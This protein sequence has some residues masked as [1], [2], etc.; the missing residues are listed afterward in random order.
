MFALVMLAAGLAAGSLEAQEWSRF[1][2]PNGTGLSEAKTVPVSWTEADFNWKTTLPGAGHSSPVLW[3]SRIFLQVA[4]GGEVAVVCLDERDGRIL[5]RKGYPQ[6][7]YHLHKFSSFASSTCALDAE[8]VYFIRQD[9]NRMFL[10]ALQ[11]TGEPAWEYPL[12]EFESQHGSGH[13]PIVFGDLVI[14]AADQDQAG[15]IVAVERKTGKL[16]WSI[17]RA[18]GDA[19]YSVPCVLEQAGKPPLLIFNTKD[20][21]IGAV[22]P[23]AGKVVWSTAP[24]VLTM[25]SIS[26]P[27]V[28]AGL[29]F[30]SCGSGG[31]GHYLIAVQ[32][33]A[34]GTGQAVVKYDVRKAAP[35]VPTPI[36]YGGLLF[37]WSDAGIVTC[38]DPAT[39]AVKWQE[40]AG[41]NY[42]ASPVCVDGR[43]Y[44]V[45]D[46]G[47]VAVIA[48]AD[49]FQV[50]ANNELGE[51]SRATPAVAN[52]KIYFRTTGHVMSLGGTKK[53]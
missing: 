14:V 26:S 22:D 1:R 33:P 38:L 50:L 3:G 41:G 19:D 48:A 23:S 34:D 35:Y 32:P 10:C 5:W 47:K 40:R 36:A 44:G 2:G 30:A 29:T 43:L 42:F 18:R 45:S 51:L 49:T 25:R 9:G 20:D 24:R 6:G 15:A 17:P 16:A 53:P 31:G 27:V 13:S 11:Q 7:S 21:G 52:G 12:G 46:T 28:A 8:R 4:Q 37:L 39:G